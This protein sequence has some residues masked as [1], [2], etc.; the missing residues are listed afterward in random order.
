[1]NDGG[2]GS[3]RRRG[4]GYGEGYDRIFGGRKRQIAEHVE[5]DI[6]EDTNDCPR[7]RTELCLTGAGLHWHCDVCGYSRRVEG[8]EP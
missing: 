6:N 8:E 2:K 4:A 1:M 7:C 5:A 3:A